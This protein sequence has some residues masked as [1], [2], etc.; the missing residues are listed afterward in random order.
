MNGKTCTQPYELSWTEAWVL[1]RH[2]AKRYWTES[3]HEFLLGKKLNEPTEASKKLAAL[4]GVLPNE[5]IHHALK[6]EGWEA[7][8]LMTR[9]QWDAF[10]KTSESFLRNLAARWDYSESGSY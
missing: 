3:A 4:G 5:I 7:Q 2:W 6:C 8:D 1:A 9:P 10:R